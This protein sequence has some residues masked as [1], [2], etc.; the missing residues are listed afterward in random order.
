MA[1]DA[2]T[3][4]DVAGMIADAIEGL[5][6]DFSKTQEETKEEF[7]KPAAAPL[8]KVAKEQPKQQVNLL[9][10]SAKDRV[11]AISEIYINR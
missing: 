6:S 4:E 3:K 8:P 9:G 1:T 7:S 11:A 5:R 10:M 2:L